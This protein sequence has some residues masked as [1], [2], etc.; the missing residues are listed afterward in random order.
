MSHEL[1][2][3]IDIAAETAT[4]AWMSANEHP[5][6]PMTITQTPKGRA[7]LKHRLLASGL[8]AEKIL[9][10]MEAT[11]TYWMQLA[12]DLHRSGFGVSVVKPA[13][14]HHFAQALLK[15]A[16]TDAIDAQTLARLAALLQPP[17]W[18][19]PPAVYEELYQRLVERDA[20]MHIQRQER[21]RRHALRQRP[22]VIAAVQTRMQAHIDFLQSQIET[23]DREVCQALCQ[24]AEWAA[25]TSY[26]RSI[27]GFGLLTTAWLLVATLNLATSHTPEQL[28]AFAGL[29]PY[30]RQSGTS[31]HSRG[32][33]GQGGHPRL[34][35]ALYMAALT[36]IRLNPTLRAFYHRLRA[37]GKPAKVALCAVARTLVHLAWALVTKQQRFDPHYPITICT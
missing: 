5:D 27:P 26:L 33:V 8:P 19:P 6:S 34:R 31:I 10:V 13:Q 37:R 16:K 2:V 12:L 36:A 11:G 14:A 25:A 4:A 9:V 29:A 18:T 32:Q 30:L 22:F 35:T 15:R 28:V 17:A 3:G 20:L 21:N 1:L 7:E 24:A 23:I